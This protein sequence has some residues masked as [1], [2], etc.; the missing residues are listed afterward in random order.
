MFY[1]V[2]RAGVAAGSCYNSVSL[3][4]QSFYNCKNGFSSSYAALNPDLSQSIHLFQPN[5]GQN[6]NQ[7][8]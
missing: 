5:I 1:L 4:H 7:N 3:C 8:S 2:M 6:S